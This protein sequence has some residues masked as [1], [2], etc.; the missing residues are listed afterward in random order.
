MFVRNFK[1]TYVVILSEIIYL[2]NKSI[3]THDSIIEINKCIKMK[4]SDYLPIQIE[5]EKY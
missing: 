3:K 4:I 1:F 2:F 5:D